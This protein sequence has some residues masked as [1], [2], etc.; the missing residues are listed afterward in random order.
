MQNNL[1]QTVKTTKE[2]AKGLYTKFYLFEAHMGIVAL[3]VEELISSMEVE[4]ES[5]V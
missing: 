4:R 1:K 2:K 5:N 3:T